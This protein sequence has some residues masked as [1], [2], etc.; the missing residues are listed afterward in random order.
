MSLLPDSATNATLLHLAI[1]LCVLNFYSSST[2]L[3]S[4]YASATFHSG[5]EAKRKS[6]VIRFRI[7]VSSLPLRFDVQVIAIYEIEC[8]FLW[9][10]VHRRIPWLIQ[11]MVSIRWQTMFFSLPWICV[12]ELT[13]PIEDNGIPS[14]LFYDRTSSSAVGV[15]T[16]AIS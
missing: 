14:Y 5:F 16:G 1:T 8:Q 9:N 7:P 6:S 2:A 4:V 12:L 10:S 13:A 11:N 15:L 3:P